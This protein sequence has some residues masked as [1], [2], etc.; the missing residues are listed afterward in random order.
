MCQLCF[1]PIRPQIFLHD[2]D[3]KLS[4]FKILLQLNFTGFVSQSL[5]GPVNRALNLV[6]KLLQDNDKMCVV[7]QLKINILLQLPGQ[8]NYVPRPPDSAPSG[9][10]LELPINILSYVSKPTSKISV[11][12][13]PFFNE[14]QY[15]LF[16]Q[17]QIP[18]FIVGITS[19]IQHRF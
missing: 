2:N 7:N 6:V 8:G 5:N 19:V 11:E 14:I 9:N 12:T 13:R 16:Q 4:T 10:F 15:R 17:K 3:G 18:S 1:F